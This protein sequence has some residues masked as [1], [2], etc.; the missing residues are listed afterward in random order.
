MLSQGFDRDTIAANTG[1]TPGQVSA[2]AAHVKMGRYPRP[3][4]RAAESDNRVGNILGELH[5]QAASYS[6]DGNASRIFLG[7]SPENGEEV[8]WNP[9]PGSGA[10]NPHVLIA[11]ES[12]YGKTYTIAGLL[13][14]LAEE[15]ISSIVVDYG[16]GFSRASL[17]KEFDKTNGL[18]EIEASRDGVDINPLQIFSSDLLGPVNVAQ[19]VADTFARVYPG[20]G[21]QQ[22]AVLRGAVLEELAAHE[23]TRDN[24][25][26]WNKDP[27]AFES[28]HRRL[29]AYS[30]VIPSLPT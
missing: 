8:F 24:A 9:D 1:V 17:P 29:I 14:E 19:R 5:D 27:P 2:V 26:S 7:I 11:G 18:L 4:A 13:A 15:R 10:A 28:I 23:I 30:R 22:H 25:D 21:I 12:G 20:I 3:I 16:R 6:Y